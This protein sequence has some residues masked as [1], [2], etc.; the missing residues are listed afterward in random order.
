MEKLASL[1]ETVGTFVDSEPALK[2][3][4]AVGGTVLG[5]SALAYSWLRGGKKRGTR[6]SLDVPPGESVKVEVG[7]PPPII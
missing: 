7:K 6:I 3:G 5:L 1:L 4:L 2:G